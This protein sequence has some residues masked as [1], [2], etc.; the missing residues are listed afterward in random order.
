MVARFFII[1]LTFWVSIPVVVL[2]KEYQFKAEGCNI[3]LKDNVLSIENNLIKRTWQWN[4]GNIITTSIENKKDRFTFSMLNQQP[5]LFL[6]K[7]EL[8]ASNESI[9]VMLVDSSALNIKHIRTVIQY[10]LGELQVRKILKIYPNCPVIACELYYRGKALN[11]WMGRTPK[12]IDFRNIE[13]ITKSSEASNMPAMEQLNL[14]GKHWKVK[15]VEFYDV[16]DRFNTLVFPVK[17]LTYRESFLYKGNL[18]MAQ[19]LENQ[20]GLFIL[21]ESP[22][23][24]SEL[25]YPSGDFL[26]SEDMIRTIGLGIDSCDILPNEWYRGYGYVTGVYKGEEQNADFALRSYQHNIRPFL[27]DRDD[28]VMLNTWGDRGQDTRVNESFCL[29]EL[30]LAAKLGITR[31]QIDDGW[32]A[33]RSGNSGFS[34]SSS[35]LD[36]SNVEYWKPHPV[37]FPNGLTPI[38][39]RGRELGIEICLWFHPTEKDNYGDWENFAAIMVQLYKDYGIRTFKVDGT[40]VWNKL[41]EIRLRKIYDRVMEASQGNIILNLDATAGRRCG[42]FYFNEYGN[43]FI[44]NR[45][46]DWG[47]YYPYW[48]LR[49]LWM[50]S[51]YMPAQNLQIE[52]LNKWRNRDKYPQNDRFSP[53]NYSFDYLFAI[54]M[55]GQ[56][57]AWMEALNLPEEA[58][59]T[60]KTIRK[61]LTVQNDLHKGMIFPIGS[62][63]DGKSWCG[64]QSIQETQGY[65]L[66]FREDNPINHFSLNTITLRGR[67]LDLSPVLGDG[68]AFS[69]VVKENGD[70]QFSL[71]APNSFVLYHYQIKN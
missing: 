28:M 8:Q 14:S 5:D 29:R 4:H 15:A 70:I 19:N 52:F 10:Q 20:N 30:E 42:Y 7:E 22:N 71:P 35:D 69:T 2:S 58:F 25:H 43:F 18:L 66:I 23:S 12:P 32:Q 48:T 46:T 21:K 49:N 9:N 41:S 34:V 31:F 65:F 3:V 59:A 64:F 36:F 6:P 45:Y 1:F 11:S 39:K 40:K 53:A 61:Y 56:P 37:R 67:K 24:N 26:V 44:E 62:E 57:L 55:M 60:G 33:G 63:P 47:N 68:E 16:T 13:A 38:V 51:K 54:T 17:A 50:L 27:K